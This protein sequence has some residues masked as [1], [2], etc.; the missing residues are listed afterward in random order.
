MPVRTPQP[1]QLQAQ[2]KAEMPR[3][4]GVNDGG[5][6]AHRPKPRGWGIGGAPRAA[7]PRWAMG[8]CVAAG[9]IGLGWLALHAGRGK[10]APDPSGNAETEAAPVD[11]VASASAGRVS[12]TSSGATIVASAG[13]L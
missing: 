8:V 4:P 10:R 7:F 12:L 2:Y 9:A 1:G 3:I 11:E 5:S 13:E 6:A